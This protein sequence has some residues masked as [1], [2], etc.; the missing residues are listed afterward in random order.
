[1]LQYRHLHPLVF[2]NMMF[3]NMYM[4]WSNKCAQVFASDF[5]WVQVYPMKT[6]SKSHEDLSLMFQHKCIPPS[7]VM[8]S[9][10]EQTLGKFCQNF[11]D[12]HCQVTQTEPYSFWQTRY[13]RKALDIRCLQLACH[14]ASGMT[15]LSLK[16]TYV[17][18]VP[19]VY[20]ALMAKFP[21]P[22]CLVRLLILASFAS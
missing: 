9:S 6:K 4:R 13:C 8:D 12:A 20:T 14:D 2:T 16:P 19:I 1:M 15:A 10:K 11:V 7:M 5:G 18:I 3:S 17:P 22:T 21:K